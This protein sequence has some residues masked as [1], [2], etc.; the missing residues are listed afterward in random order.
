[1]GYDLVGEVDGRS[2]VSIESRIDF[3]VVEQAGRRHGLVLHYSN[4]NT[5]VALT[6]QCFAHQTAHVLFP[7]EV[8]DNTAE[9]PLR[10]VQ[11]GELQ[12]HV[13]QVLIVGR[14]QGEEGALFGQGG[15]GGGGD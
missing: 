1:M 14:G 15:G 6:V 12:L 11:T 13:A 2:E 8:G 4:Q 9:L 10:N 7:V 5:N 3:I